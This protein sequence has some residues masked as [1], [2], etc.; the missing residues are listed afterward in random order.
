M[1]FVRKK[2]IIVVWIALFLVLSITEA[3]A[4]ERPKGFRGLR[5]GIEISKIPGLVPLAPK[6]TSHLSEDASETAKEIEEEKR[7]REK[8][9]IRPSDKLEVAS[10]RVDVIEYVFVKDKLTQVIMRFSDYAQYLNFKSVFLQIYGPA[11][12]EEKRRGAISITTTHSWFAK[13]NDEASVTLF[14]LEFD[15]NIAGSALMKWKGSIKKDA[16]L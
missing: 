2:L 7:K 12:R 16:G 11:D 15:G 4:W 9:Y 14:W 5:W 3:L 13:E 8:T 1:F 6:K 10:G